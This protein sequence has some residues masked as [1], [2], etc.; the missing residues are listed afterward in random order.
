MNFVKKFLNQGYL[1]LPGQFLA[2]RKMLRIK[3]WYLIM[4]WGKMRDFLTCLV[5]LL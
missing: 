4:G 5:S 2:M 3:A 1:G